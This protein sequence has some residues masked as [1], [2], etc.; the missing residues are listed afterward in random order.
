MD[1]QTEV[2]FASVA[3]VFLESGH[4][5]DGIVEGLVKQ[6]LSRNDARKVID[7]A[8]AFIRD[9][10]VR[11]NRFQ[12]G[13]PGNK[14]PRLLCSDNSC[15]CPGTETLKPGKTGFLYI[16]EDVVAS[17]KN[18]ITSKDLHDHSK[19]E[20]ANATVP[21]LV[22]KIGAERRQLDLEVAA[23]DAV[24]WYE[25]GVA[26]LRKTPLVRPKKGASDQPAAPRGHFPGAPK[27]IIICTSLSKDQINPEWVMLN[28]SLFIA[29]TLGHDDPVAT[30][31]L[32]KDWEEGGFSYHLYLEAPKSQIPSNDLLNNA[33]GMVSMLDSGFRYDPAKSWIG[34]ME[35]A[36]GLTDYV[37][38][39]V[40]FEGNE[41]I[42]L[43]RIMSG[44]AVP[45]S[46]DSEKKVNPGELG[47]FA[48]IFKKR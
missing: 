2:L 43:A 12:V 21:V 45:E 31:T 36:R 27:F 5:I 4:G 1:P 37:G 18:A 42:D 28:L 9:E 32:I 14:L 20:I 24:L 33:L 40:I 22:C 23:Q 26:P 15:P 10:L 30:R 35:D 38:F 46:R 41:K 34:W 29:S 16:S 47:W 48:R 13:A 8:N 39:S 6:G 7:R 17:R 3:R 25:K 19:T 44:Q 11:E